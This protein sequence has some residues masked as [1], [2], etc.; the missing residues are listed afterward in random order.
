MA[1]TAIYLK[2]SL[3]HEDGEMVPMEN[4]THVNPGLSGANHGVI[5]PSSNNGIGI[6]TPLD[7]FTR[8]QGIARFN[9]IWQEIPLDDE[10]RTGATSQVHRSD[11]RRGYST[12]GDE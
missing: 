2:V 3:Q 9:S 10:E 12:D 4:H 6:L 11:D 5:D 1:S 8:R 7:A